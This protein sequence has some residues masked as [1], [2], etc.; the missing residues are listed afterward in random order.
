MHEAFVSQTRLRAF[1]LI[2]R[3]PE[4][5]CGRNPNSIPGLQRVHKVN[6]QRIFNQTP[7]HDA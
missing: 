4:H 2:D 6:W 7:T 5:Y 3:F 1:N